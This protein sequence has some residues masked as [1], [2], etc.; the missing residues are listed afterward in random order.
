MENV[1]DLAAIK[2]EDRFTVP[3]KICHF[4]AL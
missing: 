2:A 4:K 1:A 3:R